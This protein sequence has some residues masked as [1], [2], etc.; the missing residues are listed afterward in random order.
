MKEKY[1]KMTVNTAHA[2][3]CLTNLFKAGGET[4]LQYLSESNFKGTV[5]RDET[6]RLFM[7]LSHKSN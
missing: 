5:S 1:E 4:P 2:N 3:I 6:F 7:R